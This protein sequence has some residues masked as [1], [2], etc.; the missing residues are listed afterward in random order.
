MIEVEIKVCIKEKE[1]LNHN[2]EHFAFIKGSLVRE[3]DLYFDNEAGSFR[4]GDQALRI[5][6]CE[7]LTHGENVSCMTYKGSKLDQISM[8]RKELE[9]QI[10]DAQTGIEILKN[11]GYNPV[12]PVV[13]LR[14]YFHNGN[15]TACLD[16]VEG[17]GDYLELEMIV[18][19]EEEREAALN[20]V[21]GL[22]AELGYEKKDIIRTSYL[23]ML[24]KK[25]I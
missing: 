10:E 2:L 7:N 23:S 20:T 24:Q 9:M 22:L 21:I 8:T 4:K 25:G 13:K 12:Q 16:Q 5:R 17:L 15:M 3:T 6:Q 19:K 18:E 1:K 11:L 14:Q